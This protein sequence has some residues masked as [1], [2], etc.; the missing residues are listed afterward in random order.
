MFSDS[1]YGVHANA[2]VC[3]M[4]ELAK[5][6]DSNIYGYLKFLLEHRLAK[7]MADERL[8][9]LAPWSEKL[10]FIKNRM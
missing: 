2:V 3:T 4:V 7:E 5:A 6:H 10:R 1:V 8:T 9:K